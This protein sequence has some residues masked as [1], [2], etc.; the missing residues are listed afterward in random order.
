M[1]RLANISAVIAK[2]TKFLYF[3]NFRMN[4]L[5]NT[6]EVRRVI[7]MVLF[8]ILPSTQMVN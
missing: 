1:M 6:N 3:L 7:S 8:G 5:R 4:Y 2:Y